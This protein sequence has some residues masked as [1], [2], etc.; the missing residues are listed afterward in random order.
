MSEGL[1]WLHEKPLLEL[2][3]N[4]GMQGT[5]YQKIRLNFNNLISVYKISGV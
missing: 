1:V 2:G 4:S 5:Y 3:I